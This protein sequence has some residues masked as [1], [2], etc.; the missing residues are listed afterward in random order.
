MAVTPAVSPTTSAAVSESVVVPLPSWPCGSAPALHGPAAEQ[1]AGVRAAGQVPSRRRSGRRVHRDRSTCRRAVAELAEARSVPSTSRRRRWSARRCESHRPRG[2]HAGGQ[3]DDVHRGQRSRRRAVAE[4]AVAVP[5]QH[6]RRRR[7]SAHS[8]VG[9]RREA[10]TP[11]SDRRVPRSAHP[12]SCHRRSGRT[13]LLPQHF[14]TPADQRA[15]V[16]PPAAMAVAPAVSPTTSTAVS[17]SSSY[18]CRVG[19]SSCIPSTSRSRRWSAR[20][21]DCRRPR[22]P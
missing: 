13:E 6:L 15:V 10:V 21:C 1:R 2:R 5:P 8:C 7:W 3:A 4:L 14:A 18:R 9:H 11:Q 20:R 22:W 17:Q 19:R 16:V 12:S